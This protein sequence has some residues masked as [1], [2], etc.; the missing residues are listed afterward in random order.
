[1]SRRPL[2]VARAWRVVLE[3]TNPRTANSRG[4]RWNPPGI[5]TL[6]FSLDPDTARAEVE[7][8]L[9]REPI[10]IRRKRELYRFEVT[11]GKVLDL[12]R[13]TDSRSLA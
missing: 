4:A 11:L 1:M 5:E 3:G 2:G 9:A 6:Y 8:L 7:A 13:V 10:P 12:R